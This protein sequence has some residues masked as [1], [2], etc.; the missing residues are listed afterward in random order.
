MIAHHRLCLRRLM[1]DKIKRNAP[2]LSPMRA[3]LWSVVYLQA[4]MPRTK[5][6][7]PFNAGASLSERGRISQQ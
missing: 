5:G 4:Q 6:N 3:M 7:N 1:K 2:Q